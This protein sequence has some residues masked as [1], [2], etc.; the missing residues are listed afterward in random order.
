M[1]IVT[2]NRPRVKAIDGPDGTGFCEQL[3][4]A[5][6]GSGEE[7]QAALGWFR[8]K[9]PADGWFDMDWPALRAECPGGDGMAFLLEEAGVVEVKRGGRRNRYRFAHCPLCNAKAGDLC[10][11]PSWRMV[12]EVP[13]GLGIRHYVERY[14]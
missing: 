8:E 1:S 7:A 9:Y 6:H 12:I 5:G 11:Y 2:K 4:S 14:G 13:S 3:W 10:A